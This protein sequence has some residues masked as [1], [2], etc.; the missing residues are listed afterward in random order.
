MRAVPDKFAL[1]PR[2]IAL[3]SF[4]AAVPPCI[5]AYLFKSGQLEL[6][7]VSKT[8]TMATKYNFKESCGNG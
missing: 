1:I 4:C 2:L 5:I 6:S 8:S 7:N 3:V